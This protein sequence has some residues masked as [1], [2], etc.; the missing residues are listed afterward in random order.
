MVNG[1]GPPSDHRR[2]TAGPPV[3]HRSTVVDGQSTG[4]PGRVLGRE[5]EGDMDVAWDITF[6][7]VERLRQFLTPTIHTLIGHV[8][9]KEKIVTEEEHDCDIPLHD[10]VMQPLT[11]Q[12]VHITPPDYVALATNPILNKQLNEFR[13]EFSDITRVAKKANGD[14]V[15][16]VKELH[17]DIKTYD[18][19]T[20]I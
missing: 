12:K 20:I 17:V 11:P 1:G 14:P 15:N 18:Y 19:K 13:E 16:N 10:G 9:D 4:G 2:T 8:H 7:D 5:D 3:N 6:K